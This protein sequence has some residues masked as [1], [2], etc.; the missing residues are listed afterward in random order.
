MTPPRSDADLPTQ[1]RNPKP[2]RRKA[3]YRPVGMVSAP[4]PELD[5]PESEPSLLL[6]PRPDAEPDW[7]IPD[8]E[9]ELESLAPAPP[10]PMPRHTPEP[11]TDQPGVSWLTVFALIWF[12]SIALTGSLY[13]FLTWLSREF[14]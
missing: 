7:L 6:D 12:S 11:Y 1:I 3:S 4:L 8:Q 13:F 10:R 5:N 2:K 9:D 14:I